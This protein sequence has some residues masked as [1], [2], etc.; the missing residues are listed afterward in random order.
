MLSCANADRAPITLPAT[1]LKICFSLDSRPFAAPAD[2]STNGQRIEG[3]SVVNPKTKPQFVAA[4]K[5]RIA[6][7]KK[8]AAAE[9][10]A[11]VAAKKNETISIPK[12][13]TAKFLVS[14]VPRVRHTLCS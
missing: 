4:K 14:S 8:Q 2:S 9:K 7:A 10:L 12:K 6:E 13:K 5:K 11:A 3:A 1:G